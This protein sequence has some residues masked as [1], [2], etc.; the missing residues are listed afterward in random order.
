MANDEE[1]T[2]YLNNFGFDTICSP[3]TETD[4]KLQYRKL[5][6]LY[7]PDMGKDKT[8]L[9]MT[10]INEAKDFLTEYLEDVNLFIYNKINTNSQHLNDDNFSENSNLEGI[11]EA[12]KNNQ[13]ESVEVVVVNGEIKIIKKSINN[14]E[15][16][17]KVSDS[18]LSTGYWYIDT[19]VHYQKEKK[20]LDDMQ[21]S[22]GENY[23]TYSEGITNDGNLYFILNIGF[24]FVPYMSNCRIH[25]FLIVYGKKYDGDLGKEIIVYPA[26]PDENYYC[27]DETLFP[28]ISSTDE[29]GRHILN[30]DDFD[31]FN[32]VQKI[33]RWL[34]TFYIWKG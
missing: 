21:D 18:P 10:K 23:F 5:A 3:L 20:L 29:L 24:E 33:L 4:I 19:P 31:D 17:T 6:K 1:I 7:H 32:I 15:L 11:L 26:N 13:Q 2:F 9:M 16:F 22:I 34:A 30:L 28:L 8:G 14:D 27:C 12:L 25:K